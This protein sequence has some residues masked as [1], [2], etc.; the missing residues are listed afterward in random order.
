MGLIGV[1]ILCF[2]ERLQQLTDLAPERFHLSTNAFQDLPWCGPRNP[3]CDLLVSLL[4]PPPV[5]RHALLNPGLYHLHDVPAQEGEALLG[6]AECL[7]LGLHGFRERLVLL[8]ASHHRS[9]VKAVGL[10]DLSSP[11][12]ARIA[13]AVRAV[14][15]ND[16]TAVDQD[17]EMPA[18]CRRR[19]PVGPRHQLLVGGPDNQLA[20]GLERD[21]R[22]E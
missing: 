5:S 13:L 7:L 4:K 18:Q 15:A 10:L 8:G 22:M 20:V 14:P 19:H 12:F 21:L 11:P 9:Q 1:R 17:G 3:P 2:R 16:Q 6:N